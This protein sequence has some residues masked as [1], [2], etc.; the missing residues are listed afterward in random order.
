MNRTINDRLQPNRYS[1]EDALAPHV[2]PEWAEKLILELRLVDVSGDEIGAVLSEVES[3]C[4]ESGAG[5]AEI[6]GDPVEYARSLDLAPK[7]SAPRTDLLKT[8]APVIAQLAGMALLPSAS[9]ALLH[10]R[11]ETVTTQTLG[12]LLLLV[13]AG[14]AVARWGTP[15]LRFILEHPVISWFIFMAGLLGMGATVMFTTPTPLWAVSPWPLA[16][17]GLALLGGGT[18]WLLRAPTDEDPV[19]Q[20]PALAGREDGAGNTRRGKAS[21]RIWAIPAWTVLL[22]VVSLLAG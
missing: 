17:L 1:I 13:L 15:I 5:A 16:L 2:E 19:T 18:A 22:V 21:L 7:T 3:H 11:S 8:I 9:V 4:A 20:P 12:G 6:F 14:L 10:G